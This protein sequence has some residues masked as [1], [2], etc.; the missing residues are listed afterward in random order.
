MGTKEAT[1]SNSDV[2]L[3]K[4]LNGGKKTGAPVKTKAPKVTLPCPCGCG[5]MPRN[6]MFVP[7]HDGRVSGWF[8]QV[9]AKKKKVGDL[10]K[11]AQAVF[12]SWVRLGKP[13]GNHPHVKE[14]ASKVAKA[15]Q[16]T[17]QVTKVASPAAPTSQSS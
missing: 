8:R 3:G 1:S 13:G 17:K 2:N 4:V 5:E 15:P 10:P 12:A 9:E 11:S 14:A 6:G 7:G 16:P